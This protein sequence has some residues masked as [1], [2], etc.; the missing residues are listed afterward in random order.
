MLLLSML[1]F[2]HN[3]LVIMRFWVRPIQS[4]DSLCR[5]FCPNNQAL[6]VPHPP[7]TGLF[8]WLCSGDVL[9]C[10]PMTPPSELSGTHQMLNWNTATTLAVFPGVRE[11]TQKETKIRWEVKLFCMRNVSRRK[12]TA[13]Q[14]ISNPADCNSSASRRKPNGRM[15]RWGS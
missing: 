9:L 6:I 15:E 3:A 10:W 11:A 8:V 1:L 14:F 2:T 12:G 7:V 4:E 5:G 13:F